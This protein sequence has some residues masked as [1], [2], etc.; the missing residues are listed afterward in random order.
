MPT[1]RPKTPPAIATTTKNKWT[2]NSKWISTEIN[3]PHRACYWSF[4]ARELT[5]VECGRPRTQTTGDG[6]AAAPPPFQQATSNNK[7]VDLASG[8]PIY[9]ARVSCALLAWVWDLGRDAHQIQYPVARGWWFVGRGAPG[10]R[11]PAAPPSSSSLR[12]ATGGGARP[13]P[14][15]LGAWRLAE[16]E[17]AGAAC[18][19]GPRLSVSQ[20]FVVF[21]PSGPGGAPPWWSALGTTHE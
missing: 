20:L 8:L 3:Y 16:A 1:S 17:A 5:Q 10:S 7:E 9:W 18:N 2:S 21:L 4:R 11:A 19:P 6:R 14:Q 12:P 15:A 13:G